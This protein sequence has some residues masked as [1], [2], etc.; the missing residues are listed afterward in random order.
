LALIQGLEANALD[1]A[2]MNEHVPSFVTLNKTESFFL[3][4]PLYLALCQCLALLSLSEKKPWI[5][6]QPVLVSMAY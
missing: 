2:V 4:K 1:G 3:V 5:Q 6:G